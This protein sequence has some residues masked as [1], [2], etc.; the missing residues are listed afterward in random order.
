MLEPL[1]KFYSIPNAWNTPD[2][3]I[4]ISGVIPVWGYG[5]IPL[6]T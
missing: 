5:W 4:N 1:E 6:F 2:K 3:L